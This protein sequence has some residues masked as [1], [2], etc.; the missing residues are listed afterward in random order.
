MTI[1]PDSRAADGT[2]TSLPLR[3]CRHRHRCRHALDHAGLLLA[4]ASV[5]S[6]EPV[7]DSLAGQ[8]HDPDDISA[9]P[10]A[11]MCTATSRQNRWER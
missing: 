3:L 8:H 11:T 6:T 1:S 9:A 5:L 7:M 2:R 4:T 10:G